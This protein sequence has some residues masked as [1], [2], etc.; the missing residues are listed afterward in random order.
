MR[1]KQEKHEL[2]DFERKKNFGSKGKI[3]QYFK[4]ILKYWMRPL[5]MQVFL[6]ASLGTKSNKL[7]LY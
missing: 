1:L 6:R 2:D 7:I 5:R 4:K 3:L